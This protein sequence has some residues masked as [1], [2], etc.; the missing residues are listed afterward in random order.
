MSVSVVCFMALDI[1]KVLVIRNWSFELTAKLWPSKANQDKLKERLK[2]E[3][4]LDRVKTNTI[5]IKKAAV[6]SNA[7]AAFSQGIKKKD[8]F[9]IPSRAHS[10]NASRNASRRGS[11]VPVPLDIKLNMFE[12]PERIISE[13][14]K[15]ITLAV[16]TEPLVPQNQESNFDGGESI[17]IEVPATLS[18]AASSVLDDDQTE[19][20]LENRN[21]DSNPKKKKKKKG[22]K[23]T[24]GSHSSIS[25]A[26][27]DAKPNDK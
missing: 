20:K 16:E 7:V 4:A 26:T 21:S 12:E 18:K 15:S 19:N 11:T 9:R 3:E 14:A 1:V 5:K 17:V 6:L 22:K 25:Q 10:R 8:S 23:A 2:K 27:N 24:E 13:R